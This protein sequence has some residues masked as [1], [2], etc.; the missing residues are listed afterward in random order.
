MKRLSREFPPGHVAVLVACFCLFQLGS[1]CPTDSDDSSNLVLNQFTTVVNGLSVKTPFTHHSGRGSKEIG[2]FSPIGFTY[3]VSL[4]QQSLYG[5]TTQPIDSILPTENSSLFTTVPP[6]ADPTARLAVHGLVISLSAPPG[7]DAAANRLQGVG[8]QRRESALRYTLSDLDGDGKDD[9]VAAAPLAAAGGRVTL[10]YATQSGTLG[11]ADARAVFEEEAAGDGLGLKI[12][13]DD[14]TGDGVAD[15][16]LA[17]PFFNG[18]AGRV[19][20]IAGGTA[21]SGS[22]G[23]LDASIAR[24][25]GEDPG[26]TLGAG[27]MAVG[28][29]TD[30]GIPDLVITSP[31]H[32]GVGR[33]YVIKGGPELSG[34]LDA[35]AASVA[36]IDGE[37][38]AA[39]FGASPPLVVDRLP[40]VPPQLWLADNGFAGG[41]GRLYVFRR[42]QISGTRSAGDASSM[43]EGEAAGDALGLSGLFLGGDPSVTSGSDRIGVAVGA[44]GHDTGGAEAGRV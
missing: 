16:I 9:M 35:G 22:Q 10:F 43:I 29:L 37:S 25:D 1:G 36:R 38:S 39:E 24:I 13:V 27:G 8:P 19:Y 18:F 7:D 40:N 28:D 26:D 4:E 42:G 12:N 33:V 11:A 32:A 44:S 23:V 15:L 6:L 41:T 3:G 20:V 21:R 2:P 14:V 17:A 34:L 5:T 30:D 31:N